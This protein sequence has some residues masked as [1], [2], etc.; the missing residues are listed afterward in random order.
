MKPKVSVI[1]PVYNGEKHIARAI[2]SLFEQTLKELEII[3]VNDGS[4]D[5]TLEIVNT[6]R[7]DSRI[8]IISQE[9]KGVS[10]ARNIGIDTAIGD[11]IGFLDSDDK[12]KSDMYEVLYQK[13]LSE[14][15]C[16]LISEIYMERDGKFIK[17]ASPFEHNR[18]YSNSQI[19]KEIIPYIIGFEDLTLLL[20]TNK[21]YKADVIKQN[22]I[23][24]KEN[25][26]LEEDGMFNIVVLKNAQN[27]LFTE[28]SGYYYLENQESV[29]R[30]FI[31]SSIFEKTIEKYLLDYNVFLGLH[32]DKNR[33]A[34]LQSSRLVYS[35]CV[36]FFK[37]AV[38]RDIPLKIK[39]QYVE[40]ILSHPDVVFSAN[41]LSNDFYK[42]T[43][44]FERL[45]IWIIR[46]KKI[47]FGKKLNCLISRVYSPKLSEILRK[48]NSKK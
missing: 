13:I 42:K 3:I 44:K 15:A 8:K 29:T 26:S 33:L 22:E 36:L 39:S 20:V 43:G 23:K 7:S 30:N 37:C 21:L 18:V 46:N 24:F 48:L 34:E 32:I 28:Y 10:A 40:K 2:D 1:V 41:N 5:N 16:I 31:N 12:I 35:V 19:Q 45:L 25:I 17:K 4:T 11:Y 47:G 27:I 9:N 14:D 38:H 6:Y